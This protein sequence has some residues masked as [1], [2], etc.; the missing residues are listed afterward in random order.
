MFKNMF[1][2]PPVVATPFGPIPEDEYHRTLA[3]GVSWL[4]DTA[5][6]E[7]Q[8][9]KTALKF[10][11]HAEQFETP[12]GKR[13]DLMVVADDENWP[14]VFDLPISYWPWFQ[15]FLFQRIEGGG[16]KGHIRIYNEGKTVGLYINANYMSDQRYILK[17]RITD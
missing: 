9:R 2:K 15:A 17:L 8:R 3:G 14:P 11:I 6:L 4:V 1:Q 10:R 12:E 13:S 16:T 5:L 7:A